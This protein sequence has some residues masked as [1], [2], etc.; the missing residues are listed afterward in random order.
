MLVRGWVLFLG[1]ITS[2]VIVK[3]SFALASEAFT[4]ERLY[5]VHP[6]IWA[7]G[8]GCLASVMAYSVMGW[9]SMLIIKWGMHGKGRAGRHKIWEYFAQVRLQTTTVSIQI[10]EDIHE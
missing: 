7:F 10:A 5:L 4:R 1:V 2:V 9:V 3:V 6:P 8:L